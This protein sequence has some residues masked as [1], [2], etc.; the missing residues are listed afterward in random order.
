MLHDILWR[1]HLNQESAA[2][3]QLLPVDRTLLSTTT[4]LHST[5]NDNV[6][7]NF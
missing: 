1:T 4:K 6:V 3:K 7:E 2:R 5:Y